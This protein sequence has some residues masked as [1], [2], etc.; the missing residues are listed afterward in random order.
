[1]PSNKNVHILILGASGYMGGNGLISIPHLVTMLEARGYSA[2]LSV[3][4]DKSILGKER[5][6]D[7]IPLMTYIFKELQCVPRLLALLE[8]TN[9]FIESVSNDPIIIYDATPTGLHT[10]HL[11]ILIKTNHPNFT[12]VG[13]KPLFSDHSD[14]VT[15][16][17][18]YPDLSFYCEFIEMQN[19]IFLA[20]RTYLDAENCKIKHMTF[21]RAGS[22]GIKKLI[23]ADRDGV[24]GGALFDKAPHDL[25]ITTG[26]LGA[27]SVKNVDI[28]SARIG[29]FLPH[30]R[31]VDTAERLFLSATNTHVADISTDYRRDRI[32][33]PA[34]GLFAAETRW[35]VADD[36]HVAEKSQVTV[37]YLFSW[38]GA[39]T[40][41]EVPVPQDPME[42]H[43]VKRLETLGLSRDD[44]LLRHVEKGP[45]TLGPP[46]HFVE[47]DDGHTHECL[48]D[49]VRIGIIDCADRTLVCNFLPKV[50]PKTKETVFPLYIKVF[51]LSGALVNSI[52]IDQAT[53][54]KQY[55]DLKGLFLARV[56]DAA[57][58]DRQKIAVAPEIGREAALRVHETLLRLH[59]KAF[60]TLGSLRDSDAAF[61]HA[62]T[63]TD[64]LWW[65]RP[66]D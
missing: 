30:Q 7:W 1:M 65:P 40:V 57:F 2:R 39:T 20:L 12:Y 37:D 53:L 26:I 52:V 10:L 50:D 47:H 9:Q 44:W 24:A 38:L 29:T 62:R 54:A 16:K 46:P 49:D 48:V 34:D 36:C 4:V 23:K 51:D 8:E 18:M 43:I 31:F 45:K 28:L 6:G 63:M 15:M 14:I 59:S 64:N 60:D 61:A 19:P 56:F 3:C 21:W 27:A 5:A 25:S 13:E 32:A 66:N 33:L 55:R 58:A 41:Q 42:A 11:N 17:T 22:S 35:H